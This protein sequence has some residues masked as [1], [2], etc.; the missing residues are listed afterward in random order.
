MYNLENRESDLKNKEDK[1]RFL[2]YNTSFDP[3][4]R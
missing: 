3:T 2:C 4:N 1:M